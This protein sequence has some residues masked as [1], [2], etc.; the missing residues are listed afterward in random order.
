[1]SESTVRNLISGIAAIAELLG[2]DYE[3]VEHGR[4]ILPFTVMRRLDCVLEPTKD[5]VLEAA[6]QLS[7]SSKNRGQLLEGAAGHP[8]YN[9]SPYTFTS[10]L[11]DP[12]NLA[13]SLQKYI[14]EFSAPVREVLTHFSVDAHMRRLVANDLLYPL[15]S[16]FRALDLR[17]GM[18]SD[19]EMGSIYEGSSWGSV[20]TRTT[21]ERRSDNPID[22]LM[23]SEQC[24]RVLNHFDR[25]VS[26]AYSQPPQFGF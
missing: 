11:S 13:T 6:S 3:P 20:S 2:D 26:S 15:M 16:R 4:V 8:Y 22:L 7:G 24:L 21:I 25:Y 18:V 10:L 9:T 14:A 1:M 12:E 17:R 19:Q 23:P 5:R